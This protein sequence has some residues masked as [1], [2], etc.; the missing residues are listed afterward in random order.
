MQTAVLPNQWTTWYANDFAAG[1]RGAD[2]ARGL[3]VGT[4]TVSGYQDAAVDDEI[5]GI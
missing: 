4:V 2:D 1:M 3:G 5:V